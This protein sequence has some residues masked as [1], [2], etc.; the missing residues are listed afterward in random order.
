MRIS[1]KQEKDGFNVGQMK[2]FR[3]FHLI[4]MGEKERMLVIYKKGQINL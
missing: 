4:I 1:I 3:L 2:L